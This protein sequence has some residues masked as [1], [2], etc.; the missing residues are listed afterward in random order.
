M[1]RLSGWARL[2]IA[3]ACVALQSC[4]YGM[5]PQDSASLSRA[6]AKCE[7]VAREIIAERWA[8]DLPELEDVSFGEPRV[9]V[10]ARAASIVW[11]EISTTNDGNA[12][13]L[14]V[15]CFARL[16]QGQVNYVGVTFQH[17]PRNGTLE[18]EYRASQFDPM[19]P[20]SY[21]EPS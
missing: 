3:C 8:D 16:N 12:P 6:K 10:T 1:K 5:T 2:W 4:S 15:D 9:A 13:W 11:P 17:G 21:V 14:F 19:G 7:S 18:Y 20:L